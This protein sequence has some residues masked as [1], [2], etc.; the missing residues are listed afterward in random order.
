[1]AKDLGLL[2]SL[3]DH[4]PANK[5]AREYRRKAAA[6]G[7]ACAAMAAFAAVNTARGHLAICLVCIAI[8]LVLLVLAVRILVWAR[9]A[10]F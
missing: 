9:Q 2:S 4:M 5:S 10:Q 3:T 1:M 8:Q 7:G 6:C